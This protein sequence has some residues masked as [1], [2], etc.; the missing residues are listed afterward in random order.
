MAEHRF[1]VGLVGNGVGPSLTPALHMR[2]ADRLGLPYIYRAVD[3]AEHG[4]D[5]SEIGEVLYLA[6]ALGYDALNITHP[7]KTLVLPYLNELDER[8]A[9]LQTV[10]TVLL[11]RGQR[12]GH[13]TDWTGFVRSF[14]AGLPGVD[15]GSVALVGAGGAGMSIGHALLFLGVRNL[16]IVD[17]LEEQAVTLAQRLQG[18][19]PDARVAHGRPEQLTSSVAGFVHC[20]PTGMAEH[21]GVAFDVGLLR[22]EHWVA[23]IVYRP[24]QTALL[25]AAEAAGCRTLNGAGMTVYQAVEAFELVTGVTP[26]ASAMTAHFHELV[27]AE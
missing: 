13:N 2:A 1:L 16:L 21:P 15:V 26:D 23:D 8:A 19:F 22:P 24:L 9:A 7:C 18:L 4:L 11:K 10:N 14:K 20:T 27:A 3:L 17:V 5:P 6:E 12:T 25:K